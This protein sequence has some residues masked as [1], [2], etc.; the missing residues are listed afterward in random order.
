MAV[1]QLDHLSKHYK[2]QRGLH[3]LSLNINRGQVYGLLGPNGSGK[4]TTMKLMVGLIRPDSG[5][6]LIL[7]E[8]PSMATAKALAGVGCLIENPI[9]YPY[10]SAEQNLALVERLYPQVSPVA[11]D[12]VLEQVGLFSY[13]RERTAH[14]SW[15]MKQRLG[16]ALALI[17]QPELLILDEPFRG[18]D[19]EGMAEVRRIIKTQAEQGR[20]IMLSSH[21]AGELE[22]LCTDV[23]VIREGRL[24]STARMQELL[25]QWDSLEAYYLH[26]IGSGKEPTAS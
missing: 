23:A 21:L 7:G 13:R 25:Q 2:N 26:L 17:S 9:F 4:T 5:R 14:Y 1:V 12:H 18:L 16:L 11:I 15:G 19:I 3:E 20:T 24:L 22:Q 8:D 6:A 10:L